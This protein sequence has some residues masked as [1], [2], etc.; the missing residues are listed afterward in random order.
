M[1]VRVYMHGFFAQHKKCLK[2]LCILLRYTVAEALYSR[3]PA[4]DFSQQFKAFLAHHIERQQCA[5]SH[6]CS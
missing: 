5:C 6:C 1:L 3:V 2:I 4:V